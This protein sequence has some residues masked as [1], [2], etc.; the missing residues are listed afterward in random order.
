MFDSRF[1]QD[2]YASAYYSGVDE[3][4]FGRSTL[5]SGRDQMSA[6]TSG[7]ARIS[8]A[9]AEGDRQHRLILSVRGRRA[10]AFYGGFAIADLGDAQIGVPAPQ[11]RPDFIYGTLTSY[12]VRQMSYAIGYEMRWRG[13]AEVNVGF[14]RTLG[15]VKHRGVEA[16]LA[17]QPAPGL[18]MVA[19]AV[20]LRPRV[21]GQAVEEGR[22]CAS[23]IGR[24]NLT[25][26]ANVDYQ[27]SHIPGASVD[28]H[29]LYEGQ[30]TANAANSAMLPAQAIFDLG[31]R[32]RMKIAKVPTLLRLQLKNATN[33]FGWKVSG[34]G[35]STLLTGRRFAATLTMD[36]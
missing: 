35:G 19:G 21:T 11:A 1:T 2:E 3:R 33:A 10:K 34:G 22:L 4:G 5:V 28:L 15:E 29:I 17:G 36:F 6:F 24:T 27:L 32:Y 30:R 16:S 12:H 14:Y 18:N 8:Q 20:Y 25:I 31:A 26:D 9:F 23:P 7:E 13:I